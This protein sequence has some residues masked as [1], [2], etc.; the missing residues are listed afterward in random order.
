MLNLKKLGWGTVIF[1]V[2]KGT[3]STFLIWWAGQSLFQSC[4]P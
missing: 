2:V 4:N 3:I 1:F